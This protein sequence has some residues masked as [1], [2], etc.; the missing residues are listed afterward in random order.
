MSSKASSTRPGTP[1]PNMKSEGATFPTRSSP[2]QDPFES[3]LEDAKFQRIIDDYHQVQSEKDSL[4][5]P[6]DFPSCTDEG[7]P[8]T[9][10][11]IFESKLREQANRITDILSKRVRHFPSY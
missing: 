10:L 11:S 3:A 6:Q 2:S 7:K 5:N 4:T 8:T 9:L 1:M